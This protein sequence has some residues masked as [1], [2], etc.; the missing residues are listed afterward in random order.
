MMCSGTLDPEVGA[1]PAQRLAEE[2][3]SQLEVYA[4]WI[5]YFTLPANV[6]M[7]ASMRR[8]FD[9]LASEEGV[10][11]ARHAE[12]AEIFATSSRLERG[13]WEMAYTMEQWPDLQPA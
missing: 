10:G 9:R 8:D 4:D 12:L 11:S 6:E 2:A 5:G 7:V 1:D 3:T 13:F